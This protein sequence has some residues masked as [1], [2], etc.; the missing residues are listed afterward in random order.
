MAS[1]Y[2]DAIFTIPLRDCLMK[3]GLLYQTVRNKPFVLAIQNRVV[4]FPYCQSASHVVLKPPSGA[5]PHTHD[6]ICI[7]YFTWCNVFLVDY[8]AVGHSPLLLLEI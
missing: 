2:L 7:I 3:A 5:Y 8:R 4:K 1:R 6:V